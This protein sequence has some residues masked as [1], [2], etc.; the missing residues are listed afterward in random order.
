MSALLRQM[1]A[2]SPAALWPLQETSGATAFDVSGNARHGGLNGGVLLGQ[3]GPAG[4]RAMGFDGVNDYVS[5]PSL[6]AFQPAAYSL[7]VWCYMP[8]GVVGG[9]TPMGLFSS[10]QAAWS[11]YHDASGNTARI[12]VLTNVGFTVK[13]AVGPF[14]RDRW[15]L[16]GGTWDGTNARLWMDGVNVATNSG[17]SG[18][19]PGQGNAG[20]AA[21]G[22]YGNA[23]LY[24]SGRLAFAAIYP[25]VLTAN[26]WMAIWQ[27]GIRSGVVAG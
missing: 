16:Q 20:P 9:R 8:A 26:Q 17:G 10:G 18:G 15:Y 24:W 5:L 7:A 11:L 25:V 23:A 21:I 12:E 1:L 27:A 4:L 3:S 22:Q 2:P 14:P 19:A 13:D 6:A